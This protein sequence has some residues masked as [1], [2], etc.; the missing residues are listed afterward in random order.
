MRLVKSLDEEGFCNHLA[1]HASGV[2]GR[3]SLCCDRACMRLTEVISLA[4]T[5]VDMV[6]MTVCNKDAK[7]GEPLDFPITRWLAAVLEHLLFA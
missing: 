6:A 2:G 1:I 4:R 3:T 5:E 7:C